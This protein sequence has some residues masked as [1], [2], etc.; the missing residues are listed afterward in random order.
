MVAASEG[1]DDIGGDGTQGSCSVLDFI[2][3]YLCSLPGQ[4]IKIIMPGFCQKVQRIGTGQNSG[5]PNIL[6]TVIYN[7]NL[8]LLVSDVLTCYFAI[9]LRRGFDETPDRGEAPR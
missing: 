8:Y 9:V 6:A 3:Q 4:G 1:R 2:F 7:E 5:L